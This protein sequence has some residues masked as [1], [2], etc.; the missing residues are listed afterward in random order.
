MSVELHKEIDESLQGTATVIKPDKPS[1]GKMLFL[2]SY[3]CAMNFADSEVV[4][5]IMAQEGYGTTADEHEA[6][7]ILINTC[8]ILDNGSLANMEANLPSTMDIDRALW[9]L[10]AEILFTDD[11][12]Y[13]YK[14]TMDYLLYFDIFF[15]DLL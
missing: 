9:F 1:N 7:I 6:D 13:A 14:G 5:S 10:A 15:F 2:E 11:D 8:S 3:G 12:G 4:A